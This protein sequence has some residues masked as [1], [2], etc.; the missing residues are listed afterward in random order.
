[1]DGSGTVQS[2]V[3]SFPVDFVDAC[4]FDTVSWDATI[5]TINYAVSTSGIPYS[6]DDAPVYTQT[7]SVC[8]V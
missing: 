4:L 5:G 8:P 2:D 7:Y 1:M 6:P 3:M